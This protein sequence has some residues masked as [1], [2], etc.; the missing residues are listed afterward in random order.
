MYFTMFSNDA[1][2]PSS[3]FE[4]LLTLCWRIKTFAYPKPIDLKMNGLSIGTL[5]ACANISMLIRP[6]TSRVTASAGDP[7][8]VKQITE[9]LKRKKTIT[10]LSPD[11]ASSRRKSPEQFKCIAL[12]RSLMSD[13]SACN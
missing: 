5:V 12:C 8:C 7:C 3:K 9:H 10:R 6:K 11:G 1:E 4:A 2:Q 13:Q